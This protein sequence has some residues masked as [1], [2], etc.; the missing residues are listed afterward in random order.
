[1]GT[2]AWKASDM[3]AFLITTADYYSAIHPQLS[4]KDKEIPFLNGNFA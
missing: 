1:M 3:W 4:K 2:A